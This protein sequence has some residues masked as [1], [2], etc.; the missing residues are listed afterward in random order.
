MLALMAGRNAGEMINLV[1][2]NKVNPSHFLL[3]I[4]PLNPLLLLV[5]HDK[6]GAVRPLRPAA[7]H[8]CYLPK[9]YGGVPGIRTHLPSDADTTDSIW[10]DVVHL[11]I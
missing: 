11:L 9:A 4:F 5:A 6:L 8:L 2:D 10:R 3:H 1:K 7:Q